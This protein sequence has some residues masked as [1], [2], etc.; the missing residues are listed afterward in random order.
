METRENFYELVSEF[1]KQFAACQM[2]YDFTQKFDAEKMRRY[3]MDLKKFVELK[4]TQK[5]KNA[6][7]V[8]FSKYED[9]IRRILD[10]YVTAE[11]VQKM[12]EPICIFESTEFNAY[13]ENA[14][15]GLSEKSKAEAIAAQTKRTI[16]ENYHKDPEFYKRFSEKIE[17]LIE[18][19]KAAKEEDARALLN[20]A[21]EI[22]GHVV[23]YED[24]DI[25]SPLKGRKEFHTYFRNLRKQLDGKPLSNEH[26][27]S[28]TEAMVAI[29]DSHKI[30]DWFKN[31]EVER[32]VRIELEDF[33]FD[34]VQDE[35]GAAMSIEEIDG[36]ISLIWDLAVENKD[37]AD[38]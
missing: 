19:L 15:R 10:K 21:R 25:P 13:I 24:N 38:S 30:I 18:E 16:K 7:V 14:E 37:E 27:T 17:K 11:Y 8:D 26:L 5:I 23:D 1:I 9:Q 36:I 28:M 33:L 4:K 29:V 3:Q 20:E 32:R 22:Q 2:L 35:Y 6:E 34:V 31:V 12:A